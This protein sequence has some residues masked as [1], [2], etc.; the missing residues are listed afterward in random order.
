MDKNNNL[1]LIK[2]L[3]IFGINTV[4]VKANGHKITAFHCVSLKH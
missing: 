1:I 4:N 2:A 3:S